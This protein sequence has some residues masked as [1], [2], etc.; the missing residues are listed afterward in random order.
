M[1]GPETV[2][3]AIFEDPAEAF[4]FLSNYQGRAAEIA[5]DMIQA[6]YNTPFTEEG[7]GLG[8]DSESI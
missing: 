2:G 6:A 3:D 4:G 8:H 5:L 1:T 7:P